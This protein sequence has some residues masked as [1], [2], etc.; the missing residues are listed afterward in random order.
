MRRSPY[1]RTS[2]AA[3][4]DAVNPHLVGV[5]IRLGSRPSGDGIS[6]DGGWAGCYEGEKNR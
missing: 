1:L 6:N 4:R 5:G 2:A 3:V